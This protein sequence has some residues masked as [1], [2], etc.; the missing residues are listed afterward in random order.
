MMAQLSNVIMKKIRK[1]INHSHPFKFVLAHV[2]MKLG[3]SKFIVFNRADYK[4]RF[5]PSALSR[6]LWIKP[7]DRLITE[8]I[9]RNILQ[10]G[11][12]MVD[13]GANIGTTVIAGSLA[14]GAV[15]KVIAFEPHP[16]TAKFLQG[17][18]ELNKLSNVEIHQAVIGEKKETVYFSSLPGDD[19]N[20]VVNKGI[21]V[22]A[23]PL[24]HF[25]SKLPNIKLL[26]IDVEG[27][28]LFVFKGAAK[29][30]AKA[31]VIM[32]EVDDEHFTELGYST[33]DLVELLQQA[34]FKLYKSIDA[35][36]LEEFRFTGKVTHRENLIAITKQDFNKVV[37]ATKLKLS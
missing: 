32:F 25:A 11:E 1:I 4:L 21:A 19:Q 6:S 30:L 13:V 2:L 12:I 23:Y 7:Q 34:G 17:N 27:Y 37:A 18:V 26:K 22:E 35:T 20:K 15:G 14:V 33:K 3:L 9:I 28:E 29:T 5:F 31:A 24:D 36:N 8:S 16:Q 10:P